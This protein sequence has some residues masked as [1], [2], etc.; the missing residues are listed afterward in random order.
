MDV[1]VCSN[2]K[3][4]L[5]KSLLNNQIP[6]LS[7]NK[8]VEVN[9]VGVF[10]DNGKILPLISEY[11]SYHS[12]HKKIA[13]KSAGTYGKNLTYFL[14]YIRSRS[15]FDDDETDEIFITI[16]KYVIQ[17]YLT[18]LNRD[19]HISSSTV[20]NRDATIR[21]FIEFLCN[22]TEDR[23]PLRKDNPYS[24]GYLSKAPKRT[25]ITSC[26][27]DDLVVLIESTHSE[28]E[29]ALLQFL[30][31]SGLRRSEIP[32]VT[33]ENFRDAA[34]FNSEKFIVHDSD[35]PIHADYVPLEVKGSKGRGNEIK[36]RW[37]LV[38]IATIKRVQKY[39]ASPLYKKH[40]RKYRN[41]AGTPAFL[42]AEGTPYTPSA[43]NKLLERVSKRAM[44]QGRLNRIIS[45]HKLRHGNAYAILQSNDLGA[46]Y[47]DRLV[48]VQKNLGHNH[49]GTTQMYTSIPQ[50]IY[51][52]MCDKNGELLTRAEKMAR[53][54]K[55]TQLRIGI[56]DIK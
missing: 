2:I 52:S 45:P 33:L 17:E 12:K 53:L 14:K 39:H 6:E 5:S 54:S 29:R 8:T 28:R 56:R 9:G 47:L 3:L 46:D 51:N 1:K 31:D 43:I 19:E 34:N 10:D 55:H 16:P 40:A 18:F 27:L 36:P 21:A 4:D 41:P 23:E 25:P 11:L 38:S 44:R 32:R 42:N 26:T 37:T 24:D 48:I 20:R 22:S 35:Q 50:E 15:D 49:L 30:Y 13:Y 7:L